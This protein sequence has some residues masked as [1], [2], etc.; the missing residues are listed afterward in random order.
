MTTKTKTTNL[1]RNVMKEALL[2]GCIFPQ[3]CT[4]GK[5]VFRFLI[6]NRP[7][8]HPLRNVII[9]SS[10]ADRQYFH[11]YCGSFPFSNTSLFSRIH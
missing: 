1:N 2:L 10:Y 11:A 8:L 4:K 6:L 5:N 3:A 7:V 9:I